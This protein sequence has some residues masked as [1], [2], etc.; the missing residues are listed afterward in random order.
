MERAVC[1]KSEGRGGIGMETGCQS[2]NREMGV[3]RRGEGGASQQSR[4]LERGCT[5]FPSALSRDG[6]R[7]A[8]RLLRQGQ[9][10]FLLLTSLQ[11]SGHCMAGHPIFDQQSPVGN[12]PYVV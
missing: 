10:V 4:L 9:L 2:R 12:C 5:L 11:S 1:L 6:C 8:L 3:G 7:S